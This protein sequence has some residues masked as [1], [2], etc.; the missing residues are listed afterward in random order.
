MA[1]HVEVTHLHWLTIDTWKQMH[2]YVLNN[3]SFTVYLI[4]TV[5]YA[6]PEC[7]KVAAV[8]MKSSS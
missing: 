5:L 8:G 6:Q 7:S 2:T 3:V 1:S 4:P